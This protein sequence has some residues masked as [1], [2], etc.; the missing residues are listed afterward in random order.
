VNI[1]LETPETQDPRWQEF[2]HGFPRSNAFH[3]PEMV[4][5]FRRSDG[6]D[7][8]PL[9][10]SIHGRVVA[11]AFPTLVKLS[12]PLPGWCSNRL[13]LY[14]SPLYNP[15]DEGTAGV[16]ALLAEIRLL[17]RRHALFVEIR[18]SELF[19]STGQLDGLAGA[20]YIPYQ[21][22]LVDLTVGRDNLWDSYS[23]F[24]RN[25]IRK[26]EKRGAI[27]RELKPGEIDHA[28]RLIT[29]LYRRKGVPVI[30]PSVFRIAYD[31]L[32][33][34]RLLRVIGLDVNGTLAAVR[35]SLNYS[36]TVYDWYAASEPTFREYYPNE[37]LTWDT[38]RWGS[39]EGFRIFDFGGG[40]IRGQE[41]GPARFKEKFRG[42]LV[43]F[44][45][46]R[47]AHRPRVYWV[48]SKLYELRSGHRTSV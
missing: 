10:A 40:A 15:N 32:S 21:N 41:Y 30:N 42:T 44:G 2:V 4:E 45:R 26:S 34:R 46:H 12:L 24:T 8:F 35:M 37:A 28:V 36:G 25:H 7:V 9:F 39:A 43:E 16:N 47:F 48:A 14:A 19:P 22:Y 1:Q 33:P 5:V 23:T 20:T 29:D 11:V 27:V 6:F 38:I 18:H 31:L 13:I 3:S 17:G